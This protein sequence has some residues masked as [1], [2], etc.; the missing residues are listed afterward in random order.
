MKC[1]YVS[2]EVPLR[3]QAQGEISPGK[4]AILHCTTA[5]STPPDLW[6]Q[7]LRDS[8]PARLGRQRL[9]SDS[10]TS[11]RSFVTRFLPTLGHPHAVALHFVRCGQLT[12]GLA[13]PRLCPCWAH[14]EKAPK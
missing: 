12:G 9:L 11:A 3:A 14:K 2:R 4:N 10:C 5:G 1:D 13:H 6:P 8:M 7:K